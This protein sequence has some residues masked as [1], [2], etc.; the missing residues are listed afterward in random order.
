MGA[1]A[2]IKPEDVSLEARSYG[3]YDILT[4]SDVI[5]IATILFRVSPGYLSLKFLQQYPQ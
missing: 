4:P 2:K 5:N 1:G 3:I